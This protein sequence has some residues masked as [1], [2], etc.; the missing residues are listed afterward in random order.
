MSDNKFN[1]IKELFSNFKDMTPESVEKI[2][3]ET[4]KIFTE[5][6]EKLNSS[7]EE[8]KQEALALATELRS[9]LEEQAK[10][11]MKS[12]G[13]DEEELN[14]FLNNPQNFS[15]EEWLSLDQAKSEMKDYR[16][17]LANR[18]LIKEEEIKEEK[19]TKKS[20]NIDLIKG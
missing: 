9:L 2:V 14:A 12:I 20:K 18:G 16:K 7:N 4:L 1:K 10:N 15:P 19:V 8:E 13:M 17:E 11:A 6:T 3:G 5:I